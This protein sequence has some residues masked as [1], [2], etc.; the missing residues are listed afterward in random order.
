MSVC[1]ACGNDLSGL[2]TAQGF[3]GHHAGVWGDDWHVA[4]RLMCGLIHR[5]VAP[6]RLT[7]QEREEWPVG[8]VT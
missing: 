3:C 7:A 4:N 5:R 8:D 2:D 6:T 1:P